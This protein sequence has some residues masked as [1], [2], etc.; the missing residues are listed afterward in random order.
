VGKQSLPFYRGDITIAE[1]I[2]G[3]HPASINVIPLFED[4][5]RMIEAGAILR[6]YLSGKAV[7]QQRVFLARSDPALNYG[8][9]SAVLLNKIALQRLRRLSGDRGVAI[10]PILGAGSPPFRGHLTPDT[11]DR[12]LE[13]YPDVRT[14]TVQSAFKYDHPAPSVLA[15][16]EKLKSA[17]VGRGR[18][19]DEGKCLELIDRVSAAYQR[20][21]ELLA[22]LVN[23]VAAYVPQRRTRK[24]HIGLFGYARSL[25]AVVLPRAIGFCAACYSL[26]L[27]PEILGLNALKADDLRFLAE[28]HVN[29]SFDLQAAMAF[30]NEDVLTLLPDEVKASLRLDWGEYAVNEEHRAVTSRIISAVKD[31]DRT[32]LQALI[33]EAAHLRMFLG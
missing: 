9:V 30:F 32:N 8:M 23:Y 31:S 29:F 14:F 26:G 24:L 21:V 5:E 25:D 28:V 15:A 13:E 4:R 7:S 16:V 6:E 22:P 10:H 2:G 12:V 11:V 27:P 17:R 1:W 33:I 19:I 3:F 18:D 20:Q